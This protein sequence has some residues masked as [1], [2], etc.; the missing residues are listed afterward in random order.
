MKWQ[1]WIFPSTPSMNNLVS[2]PQFTSV[3]EIHEF[4][5]MSACVN[6]SNSIECEWK[7]CSRGKVMLVSFKLRGYNA[8]VGRLKIKP[9]IWTWG[10]SEFVGVSIRAVS[11]DRRREERAPLRT[12]SCTSFEKEEEGERKMF[13]KQTPIT[14][15]PHPHPPTLPP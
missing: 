9:E 7:K 10:Q 5:I 4:Q 8:T 13:T 3:V 15:T 12:V 6:N 11:E 1:A 2:A 14:D